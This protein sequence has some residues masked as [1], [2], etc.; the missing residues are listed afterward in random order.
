MSDRQDPKACAI[1][2][3]YVREI[4]IFIPPPPPECG[5]NE[6]QPRAQAGAACPRGLWLYFPGLLGHVEA[7][8]TAQL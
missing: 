7:G 5:Q 8:G 1:T 2:A 4:R 3:N 6:K